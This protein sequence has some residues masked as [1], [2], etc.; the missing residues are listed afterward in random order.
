MTFDQSL[1]S[2]KL[3]FIS[4]PDNMERITIVTI[5]ALLILFF[6][7]LLC[8]FIKYRKLLCKYKK[9]K[10]SY[11]NHKAA[12][13]NIAIKD[14]C[15]IKNISDDTILNTTTNS[16]D[17]RVSNE[18]L[19]DA[20][21][22]LDLNNNYEEQAKPRIINSVENMGSKCSTYKVQNQTNQYINAKTPI[23]ASV[24]VCGSLTPTPKPR[25]IDIDVSTPEMLKVTTPDAFKTSDKVMRTPFPAARSSIKQT[26]FQSRLEDI[27]SSKLSNLSSKKSPTT[28]F[29]S[30]KE[31][32]PI[33]SNLDT[34]P[35]RVIPKQ[36]TRTSLSTYDQL[37]NRPVLKY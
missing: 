28:F 12:E 24:E 10:Y 26:N 30:M 19:N 5:V 21:V 4:V 18:I 14:S 32:K 2:V 20:Q 22:K 8:L 11:V 23:T 25:T 37:E 16:Q 34:T 29:V 13:T 1:N 33:D 17:Y 7:L 36:T 35:I 15:E 27:E 6:C 3:W 9:I 31:S